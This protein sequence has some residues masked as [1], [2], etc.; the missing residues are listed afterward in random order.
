MLDKQLENQEKEK[1]TSWA[2]Y[3]E[4]LR[5]DPNFAPN[6]QWGSDDIA[7]LVACFIGDH[8]KELKEWLSAKGISFECGL[9][10]WLYRQRVNYERMVRVIDSGVKPPR[11]LT[12]FPVCPTYDHNND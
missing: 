2:A 8:E 6:K 12:N 3:G 10:D 4:Y 9:R 11:N 7:I 1:S 5:S